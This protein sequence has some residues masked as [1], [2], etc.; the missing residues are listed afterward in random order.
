VVE[1]ERVEDIE[2][3]DLEDSQEDFKARETGTQPVQVPN[4]PR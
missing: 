4:N 3:K 2:G 1:A